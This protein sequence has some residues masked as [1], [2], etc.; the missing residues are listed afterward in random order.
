MLGDGVNEI[1]PTCVPGNAEG[2]SVPEKWVY[3][4]RRS[5]GVLPGGAFTGPDS[6]RGIGRGANDPS[7]PFRIVKSPPG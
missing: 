4:R 2:R 1:G 3:L 6:A 5:H 7:E